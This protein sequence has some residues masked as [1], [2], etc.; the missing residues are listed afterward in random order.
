MSDNVM[1]ALTVAVSAI[2][3]AAAITTIYF[4]LHALRG[5]NNVSSSYI[6][7]KQSVEVTGGSA[8]AVENANADKDTLS[9][10]QVFESII[11]ASEDI[12][13]YVDGTQISELKLKSARAGNAASVAGIKSMLAYSSY[14]MNTIFDTDGTRDYV[15]SIKFDYE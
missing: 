15:V 10:D 6:D 14:K 9:K 13:I 8:I 7:E 1:D 2:I 4:G 5:V 11:A 3:F 12:S